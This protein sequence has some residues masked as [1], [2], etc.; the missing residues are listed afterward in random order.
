MA[1]RAPDGRFLYLG[2]EPASRISP[3]KTVAIPIPPGEILP[4]LPATGVHGLDDV[5]VIRGARIIA[6]W[7]ISPGPD[8]S[9]F[10][11]LKTT[12]HRNLFQIALPDD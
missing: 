9:A 10:A 6:G 8:P 11:F 5:A 2:L 1:A 4:N 7:G 12:I 3:G